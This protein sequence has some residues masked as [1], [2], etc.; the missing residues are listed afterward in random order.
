MVVP[1]LLADV[2]QFEPGVDQD[3]VGVA[4]GDQALEIGVALG[5]GI[6]EMPGGHVQGGDAGIAPACGEVV[7]V[8]AQAVGGI[9]EGPQARGAEGRVEA[10]IGKSVQQVGEALVAALT[11]RNG[12][13][14]DCAQSAAEAG[15]HG[16]AGP[17][18]FGED[19]GFGGHFVARQFEAFFPHDRQFG[20]VDVFEA[21]DL[22]V[23]LGSAETERFRGGR[24]AFENEIS[25]RFDARGPFGGASGTGAQHE[26]TRGGGG[27]RHESDGL[28][29][30]RPAAL[31]GGED[32]EGGDGCGLG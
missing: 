28:K 7:E 15:Q 20:Q 24:F 1:K 32:G 17:A 2:G 26:D 22:D 9:E 12:Q 13:P 23:F 5:I 30:E 27:L 16:R 31:I 11:W 3:A 10:E 29:Q 6:V 25:A 8:H 19:F 4:G 18:I 14:E 21:G